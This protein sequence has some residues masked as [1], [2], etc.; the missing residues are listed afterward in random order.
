MGS[1]Q[2]FLDGRLVGQPECVHRAWGFT[3]RSG[4]NVV[5]LCTKPPHMRMRAPTRQN[6]TDG[7]DGSDDD[8]C[9]AASVSGSECS[10]DGDTDAAGGKPLRFMDGTLEQ[11]ECRPCDM[12]GNSYWEQC[13]IHTFTATTAPCWG[14]TFPKLVVELESTGDARRAAFHMSMIRC[15]S[16]P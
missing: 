1:Q 3:M 12:T 14:K 2:H 6:R 8:D 13:S 5:H 15:K 11:Y 9:D 7:D 10:G 4:A 16:T